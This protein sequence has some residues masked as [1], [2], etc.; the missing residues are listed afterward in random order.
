MIPKSLIA[1]QIDRQNGI[2]QRQYFSNVLK[3]ATHKL[4]GDHT[5][6]L[7]PNQTEI[8][9]INKTADALSGESEENK[10]FPT[11]IGGGQA[12]L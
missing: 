1:Q 10:Y 11:V 8:K 5:S 3:N 7:K 6:N 9:A 4:S 2:G 12:S